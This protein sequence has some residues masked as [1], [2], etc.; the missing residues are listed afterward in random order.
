MRLPLSL[1]L[2]GPVLVA[3]APPNDDPPPNHA[4]A[5]A[6]Y[7]FGGEV[8]AVD[9]D[10]DPAAA[11]NV[12]AALPRTTPAAD[13]WLVPS[14]GGAFF[15]LSSD[16]DGNGEVLVVVDKDVTVVDVVAAGG[17]P[18]FLEG[19]PAVRDDGAA[20]FFAASGGPHALDLWRSDRD[21]SGAWSAPVLLTASSAQP[22]NNQPSLT[23]DEARL[24]FN[25]GQN[26]DPETGD[27]SACAVDVDG[28]AVDVVAAPDDLAAGRNSFVN[29]ARDA[30]DGRIV[31][32]GSW[33][34]DD[35]EPPETLWQKSGAGAPTPAVARTFDN[36]VS[37]CVLADASIVALWLGRGGSDGAHELTHIRSDGSFTTLAAIDVDDIGIGCTT[38]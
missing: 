5:I 35:G 20:V 14:V 32:E 1:A 22:F 38:R 10:A 30:G 9:V 25:C 4:T 26:R 31:F 36:T 21:D 29:F 18:V 19:M 13:R 11:R 2:L 16:T 6:T 12:S 33:P 24:L 7:T 34:Q 37:P 28:G 27:N 3:C 17:A 8:F 23:R 15:A